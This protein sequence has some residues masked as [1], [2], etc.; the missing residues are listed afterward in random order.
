MFLF[1]DKGDHYSKIAFSYSDFYIN[2]L[3]SDLELEKGDYILTTRI[4]WSQED[5]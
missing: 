4:K 3:L 2:I 1:Q 5:K